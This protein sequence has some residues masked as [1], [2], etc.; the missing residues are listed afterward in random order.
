M[1][2]YYKITFGILILAL[3]FGLFVDN[4]NASEPISCPLSASGDDIIVNFNTSEGLRADKVDRSEISTNTNIPAGEYEITVVTWDGHE[5]HSGPDQTNERV[6]LKIYDSN[7]SVLHTTDNTKDIPGNRNSQTTVVS[8]SANLKNRARKI[9]AIHPEYPSTSPESVQP[10]CAKF[11]RTDTPAHE[12]FNI[13][14]YVNDTSV[15]EDDLVIYRVDID[16]GNAPFRYEWDGDTEGEDDDNSTLYV[17]YDDRGRYEVEVTVW[18]DDG[19]RETDTCPT[20]RVDD[21]DDDDLNVRCRVSDTYVDRGDRVTISV[22]IDDGDSPYDIHWSGDDYRIDDFNDDRRRQTVRMDDRGT[23][24]L[25]VEVEDDDGDR[26]ADSCTIRV[27]DNYNRY[28]NINVMSDSNLA[29]LESV[30]LSQVPYTGPKDNIWEITGFLSLLILWSVVLSLI[31][32]K[33][34]RKNLK[35]LSISQFKENN[36]NR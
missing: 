1:K 22:D 6:F 32:Y 34:H 17:R 24:R 7:N 31:L 33:R 15:D 18:D 9:T 25:R 13:Q 21:E 8:S 30:Y 3:T 10:I 12:D 23:Y 19:R 2:N 20:V 16:G 4:V 14:C 36:K 26:D 11:E 27:G 29:S 35:S 28:R 5:E